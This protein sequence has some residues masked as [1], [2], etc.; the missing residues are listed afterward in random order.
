MLM[1]LSLARNVKGKKKRTYKY[2]NSKRKPKENMGPQLNEVGALVT[3]D[4]EEPE[5]LNTFFA[6]VLNGK[7]GFQKYQVPKTRGKVWS[8][9]YFTYPLWR[10][11]RLGNT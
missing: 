4:T 11:A 8:K 7:T 1:E 3:E 9:E 6:S 10:R 5:V 2:I